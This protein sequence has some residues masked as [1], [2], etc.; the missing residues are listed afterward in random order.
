MFL[1]CELF[2]IDGRYGKLVEPLLMARESLKRW[3]K[4]KIDPAEL[5]KLRWVEG[6]TISAIAEKYYEGRRS[7]ISRILKWLA[8]EG[9]AA[10]YP[11]ETED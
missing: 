8:R 10:T 4:R 3:T 9:A 1:V 11:T 5:P 6:P 7:T 2:T